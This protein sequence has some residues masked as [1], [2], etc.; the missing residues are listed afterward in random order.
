LLTPFLVLILLS[1]ITPRGHIDVLNRYYAKMNTPVLADPQAD[2]KA[3]E[4][5]Y[6]HPFSA[7]KRKLFPASDWE[8]VKPT[9]KDVVG[10]AASCVVCGLIIGLLMLLASIGS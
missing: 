6:L 9:V 8:F 1:Y 3:L 10:F 5:A 7:A 4:H 2:R